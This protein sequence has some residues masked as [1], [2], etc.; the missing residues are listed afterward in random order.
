MS[1]LFNSNTT[2]NIKP[3]R[4]VLIWLIPLILIILMAV[5][6]L[7]SD[8]QSLLPQKEVDVARARIGEASVA[9]KEGETLF[10]AA[11]WIQPDP[12]STRITALIS[13]VVKKIHVIDG[14]YVKKGQLLVELD[15]D[16]LKLKLA[17]EKAKLN[18]LILDKKERE[19]TVTKKNALLK[20]VLCHE[21]TAK[22][23]AKRIK[24]K[25]DSYRSA[26]DALPVF[27]TEQ[28]ELEYEE[29]LKKIAEFISAKEILEAEIALAKNTVQAAEAK[30]KTQKTIIEKV[31]LDLSRTKIYSTAE[32]IIDHFHARVGRKQMLGS[33]NDKSTTV[34]SVFN[35]KKI[36]V[37]VDVPLVDIPK[38]K[39]GQ[40]TEI[41]TEI[42]KKPL[43]GVVTILNGQADYQKNTLQV[44]VSIPDGHPDLRPEMIAQVKFLSDAPPKKAKENKVSGVFIKKESIQDGSHVWIV[45]SRMQVI[46]KSVS[47]G[48]SENDGWVLVTSGINA[49]EKVIVSPA[50]DIK[51]GLSVKVGKIYE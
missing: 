18:E 20:Q 32:G 19:L 9:T 43:K 13:G 28:A 37:L 12:Y 42:L 51:E 48:N 31:E 11:G 49:G 25:A 6:L 36:Q 34:A 16:D 14:Q 33:D 23:A 44:R 2:S 21:E 5:L 27:E 41:H 22:A 17:N 10:Q 4:R 47:L 8:W 50:A 24:H 7:A 30:I 45:D 29:Q 40:K 38:V 26:K 3:P 35:P 46:K 15:D 1:N 39:I